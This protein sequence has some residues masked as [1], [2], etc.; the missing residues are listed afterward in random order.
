MNT[1]EEG[2]IAHEREQIN[3]NGNIDVEKGRNSD[4][5]GSGGS[6]MSSDG[7]NLVL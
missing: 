2:A 4:E 6:G 1:I 5:L 3:G 7:W